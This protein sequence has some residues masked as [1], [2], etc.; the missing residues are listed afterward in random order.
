MR[1]YRGRRDYYCG[2]VVRSCLTAHARLIP[3]IDIE[4]HPFP[5]ES[6]PAHSLLEIHCT[7]YGE[8]SFFVSS[9]SLRLIETCTENDK[10]LIID[11]THGLRGSLEGTALSCIP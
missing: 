5:A 10:T 11:G 8:S 2:T 4:A 1:T 6:N 3:K 7:I 9:P